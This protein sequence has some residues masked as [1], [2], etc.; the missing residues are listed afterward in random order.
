M[1]RALGGVPTV[2]G[3]VSSTSLQIQI[4]HAETR[5]DL[6]YRN[7][8]RENPRVNYVRPYGISSTR[9][10]CKLFSLP[11]RSTFPFLLLGP[12]A[13]IYANDGR[14]FSRSSICNS[15]E[16]EVQGEFLRATHIPGEQK[17]IT[18][19]HDCSGRPPLIRSRIF[20]LSF[21]VAVT[22]F[23]TAPRMHL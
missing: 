7:F 8:S 16:P 21:S 20:V 22:S 10:F 12:Y 3:P 2:Y 15:R 18:E 13:P 1:T 19:S 5:T 4:A 17:E 9:L 23:R 11:L 14:P 6:C